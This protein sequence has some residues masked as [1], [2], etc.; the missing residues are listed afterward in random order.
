MSGIRSLWQRKLLKSSQPHSTHKSQPQVR[1]SR[2]L[3]LS[4]ADCWTT[5]KA[6]N[7]GNQ[8]DEAT[9]PYADAGCHLGS[10]NAEVY[11]T[12]WSYA[13]AGCHLGSVNAEVY[14]TLW[15]YSDTG[16]HLG[17]A[18]PEAHATLWPYA[19]TGCHLGSE[20]HATIRSL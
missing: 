10:I 18:N 12:L 20:A 3:V 9:R 17:N 11:A 7:G 13:D 6:H 14:T 8:A 15:P 1:L 19:D 2:N 4:P 5:G 16:C